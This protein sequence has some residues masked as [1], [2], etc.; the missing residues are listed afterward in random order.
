M[1]FSSGAQYRVWHDAAGPDVM[2]FAIALPHVLYNGPLQ[3]QQAIDLGGDIAGQPIQ[4]VI[5]ADVGTAQVLDPLAGVTVA[6]GHALL[7]AGATIPFEE[8][9]GYVLVVIERGTLVLTHDDDVQSL[10]HRN[11]RGRALVTAGEP[12]ALH[13][14]GEHPASIL[15]V[16]V[17]PGNT[18]VTPPR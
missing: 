12:F 8:A 1:V 14:L 10:D 2:A 3:R 7:M 6:L 4:A 9:E 13:N 17:L 11:A 18:L 16:T 5:Q 15:M